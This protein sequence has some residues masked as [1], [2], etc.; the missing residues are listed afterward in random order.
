MEKRSISSFA[1]LLMSISAILGSGWLFSAYYTAQYAGVS[2]L[3]SWVIG[4]AIV[5]VIAFVFAELSTVI[6]VTGSSARI[7]HYTHGSVVSFIFAWMVLLSYSTLCAAEVQAV[8]QYASYFLPS[9]T[10]DT[11]GLT[12]TG[13]VMAVLLMLLISVINIYSLRWLVR[14]N[15]ILTIMKVV[16]P[17]LIALVILALYFSLTHLSHLNQLTGAQG[18]SFNFHNVVMAIASGGIVFSFNGFK[19]ACEVAGEAKNPRFG[20]PLAII[21]SVLVCLLVFLLL[22]LSFLASL[23]SVNLASGWSNLFL[24]HSKSP[25][26]A[27]LVQDNLTY[28]TPLLYVAAIVGP[29]AAALMYCSS[30]GR[31]LYGMSK[32]GYLPKFFQVL[33]PQ[34]NP[35]F[36]IMV[37]FVLGMATFLPFSGWQSMVTFLSSILAVTYC[38]GPICLIALRDQV[39][40]CQRAFRLPFGMVWSYVAFYLCTL[41]IYWSGWDIVSKLM[42]ALAIGAVILLLYYSIKKPLQAVTNWKASIWLW[43]YFGGIALISH[44]GNFGAGTEKLHAPWDYIYL[45]LLCLYTA[46]LSLRYKLSAKS[47]LAYLSEFELSHS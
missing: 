30:A 32:N 10:H 31:S 4:G 15:S 5:I 20:L 42:I 40:H 29:F 37:N 47:T 9:L 18:S 23:T 34:G 28:L 46:D 17:S 25:I 7:P 8:I 6:P 33:T 19:Q 27:I 3:L 11:G 36:G 22:Q 44:A 35:I 45:G 1:L 21:G 16:I 41:L 39:P 13:T 26:Q 12:A 43:V 14:C 24:A 38:I 2:A